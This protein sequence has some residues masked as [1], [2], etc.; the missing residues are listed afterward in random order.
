MKMLKMMCL[1]WLLVVGI[2]FATSAE[3]KK[4]ESKDPPATIT[5]KDD[6]KITDQGTVIGKV[7]KIGDKFI[8]VTSESGKTAH[9]MPEWKG[10]QKGGPDKSI[11]AII[12][13][14]KIG[15]TVKIEW[16]ANDH[17]RIKKIEKIADSAKK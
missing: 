8:E 15:D 4:V 17:I 7:S 11:M 3:E 16:Y 13:K 12:E 2:S 1:T 5:N 9:Y 14:L 6:R 10:G